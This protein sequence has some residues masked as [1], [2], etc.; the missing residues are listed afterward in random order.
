MVRSLE[1]AR[2]RK[3]SEKEWQKILEER[4]TLFP[5]WLG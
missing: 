2:W 4:K 5:V 3:D 1:S